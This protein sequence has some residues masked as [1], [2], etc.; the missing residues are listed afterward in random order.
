MKIAIGSDHGGFNLKADIM[1]YL[2]ELGYEYADFGTYSADSV[3]YPDIAQ[4]VADKVVS[5]EFTRGILL[6]GTGIGIGIAANKINGIR[7]ALCHDTFSAHASREHNN[8]NIL[9]MGER[10]IGRGLARDIVRIWLQT[11]FEG[12]RHAI[13]VDKIQKLEGD[14]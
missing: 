4:V 5:G 3:D 2:D 1:N 13:R 14:Y 9:T 10:V 7:A 11:E 6:C 8:A 12:G